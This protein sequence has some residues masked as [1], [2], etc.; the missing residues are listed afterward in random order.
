VC[1]RLPNLYETEKTNPFTP[2]RIAVRPLRRAAILVAPVTVRTPRPPNLRCVSDCRTCMNLKIQ[3]IYSGAD[4]GMPPQTYGDPCCAGDSSD[5][6]AT[7]PQ[8]KGM[9]ELPSL[10]ILGKRR[11]LLPGRRRLVSGAPL[12]ANR[13]PD[14]FIP[15]AWARSVRV[16]RNPKSPSS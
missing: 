3:P 6:E 1:V 16:K 15:D 14:S 9:S 5:S 8:G 7:K 11:R 10:L 13:F 4:R 12:R 2:A